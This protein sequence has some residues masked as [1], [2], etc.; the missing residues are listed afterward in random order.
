MSPPSCTRLTLRKAHSRTKRIC[1]STN[2]S[3]LPKAINSRVAEE[4]ISCQAKEGKVVDMAEWSDIS[5]ELI[6]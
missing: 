1:F 5:G 6:V 3:A 2:R 4:H